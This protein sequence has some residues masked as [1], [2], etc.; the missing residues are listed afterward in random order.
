MFF[1]I[2]KKYF[3]YSVIVNI[4]KSAFCLF[5][6]LL[7][8]FGVYVLQPLL[9]AMYAHLKIAFNY[10]YLIAIQPFIDLCFKQYKFL[11]DL[12]FIY[13]L[14]PVFKKLIDIIPKKNPFGGEFLQC[15]F[16]NNF[17]LS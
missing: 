11:E 14:G 16:F 15:N 1:F 8:L 17:K 9:A 10:F 3:F 2:T 13:V 4:N 12:F 6:K 7:I 5:Q